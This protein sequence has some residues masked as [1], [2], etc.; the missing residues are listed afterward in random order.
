MFQEWSC[1]AALATLA[2]ASERV[3]CISEWREAE[4]LPVTVLE[5]VASMAREREGGS[6]EDES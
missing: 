4:H 1:S 5:T 6:G 3:I 2:E